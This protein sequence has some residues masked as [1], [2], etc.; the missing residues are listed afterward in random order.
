MV[1][2]FYKSVLFCLGGA[3]LWE[4]RFRVKCV[5]V[6]GC[7]SM[8]GGIVYKRIV[9]IF[10]NCM[11]RVCPADGFMSELDDYMYLDAVLCM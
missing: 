5:C 4:I 9:P 7:K 10:Y 8:L 3:V 11:A 2:L 6:C 1:K